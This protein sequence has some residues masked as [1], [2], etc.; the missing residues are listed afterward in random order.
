M[1]L[2]IAA[3]CVCCINSKLPDKLFKNFFDFIKDE[4]K[5]ENGNF[6]LVGSM[7]QNLPLVR[8]LE[9]SFASM[10]CADY[11]Q[12]IIGPKSLT[13][14]SVASIDDKNSTVFTKSSKNL[15]ENENL[16]NES[17][18]NSKENKNLFNE[19]SERPKE[20]KNLFNESAEKSKENKSLFNESSE[21][22]KENKNLTSESSEQS[23]KS[24]V[25]TIVSLTE[26][27][28]L[29][30]NGKSNPKS[31][32]ES[33][34]Y[35]EN[36]VIPKKFQELNGLLTSDS[37]P[38]NLGNVR[39]NKLFSNQYWSYHQNKNYVPLS[40][41]ISPNYK[42]QKPEEDDVKGYGVFAGED[43]K[44]SPSCSKLPVGHRYEFSGTVDRCN[45]D[46][47]VTQR[48]DFWKRTTETTPRYQRSVR[49]YRPTYGYNQGG[50][51]LPW[52]SYPNSALN[53]S[54]S[55]T[56]NNYS[57]ANP[58]RRGYGFDTQYPSCGPNTIS[59]LYLERSLRDYNTF[60]KCKCFVYC[61]QLYLSKFV[62]I[63]YF[64]YVKKI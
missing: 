15:N 24:S 57:N 44:L 51:G 16:S 2:V 54:G 20:N 61:R 11:S 40:K 60:K 42:Y 62:I 1:F 41:Q 5:Q 47:Y 50:F 32:K 31:Y 23:K 25:L 4:N 19:S 59:R 53:G 27:K 55:K 58:V 18:E 34:I 13:K 43:I 8:A 45:G 63:Q 28:D 30:V 7:P 49:S 36:A 39:N 22:S 46:S 3:L 35:T 29:S 26:N 10:E 6:E 21:K 52:H 64:H 9:K 14:R 48:L 37:Q 17:S 38:Q 33:S 56:S 12:G